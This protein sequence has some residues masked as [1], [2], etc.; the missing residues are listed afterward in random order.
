MIVSNELS[1]N[2]SERHPEVIL[3]TRSPEGKA[4]R[5]NPDNHT[6]SV[7]YNDCLPNQ[8]GVAS[9]PALPK[10]VTQHYDFLVSWLFL[11]WYERATDSRFHPEEVEE[12]GRNARTRHLL[13]LALSS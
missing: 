6:R 4:S 7:V 3:L 10:P 2:E 1:T 5:K 13:G 8:T 9:K 12:I 11:F